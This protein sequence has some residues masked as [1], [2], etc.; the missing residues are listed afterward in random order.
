MQSIPRSVSQG[1]V[2][3]MARKIFFQYSM[4]VLPVALI[5]NTSLTCDVRMIRAAADVNPEETGPDMKSITNPVDKEN[6]H[7]CNLEMCLHFFQ[8]KLIGI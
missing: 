2:P 4:K 7:L 8:T 3:P 6:K 5:P 1:R